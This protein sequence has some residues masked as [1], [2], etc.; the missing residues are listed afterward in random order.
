MRPQRPH[1]SHSII[2]PH[3]DELRFVGGGMHVLPSDVGLWVTNS[4]KLNIQGSSKLS[5]S[6]TTGGVPAGATSITLQHD[7]VGWRVGDEIAITPTLSPS[8]SDHVDSYDL[9]TVIGVDRVTR[10]VTLNSPTTFDHPAVEVEP[11]RV[12]TPE[13]L[14][15]TRNV[16]IE[17]M[18]SRRTHVWIRSKRT[19]RIRN[20]ALRYVGPRREGVHSLASATAVSGR[21][22]LHFH[23]MDDASRGSIVQGVV[24]RDGGSHAF[25]AHQS[26]GVT[27]RD[28]ISHD[29]FGDAYWWDQSSDSTLRSPPTDDVVYERCVAS[30]VRA[31]S[32]AEGLRMG[33]FSLGARNRNAIRNCVAVGVQGGF[34]ASG[35]VWPETSEGEWTFEDCV[36][37]NNQYIGLL[38]WQ[39]NDLPQVIR[40]FIGYHNGKVGIHNGHYING[41][42]YEDSILYANGTASMFSLAASRGSPVQTFSGLRCDQAG[43]SP[44]CVVNPQVAAFPGAAIHFVGCTFRGYGKAALAFTDNGAPFPNSFRIVNCTYEGNEF[45]LGD[46]IHPASR[47][48]IEDPRYGALTLRRADQPGSLR[49]MWNASVT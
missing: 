12:L 40:R 27:F 49:P 6:R 11:G 3:I 22:G 41:F 24:I 1:L 14:N 47:I 15:L 44:Y 18:P 31:E 48:L 7:P 35:F 38:A 23:V 46:K 20:A 25:V 28:C 45:W 42:V 2:F 43:L 4:G 8:H 13:V 16:R 26:H 21:Y 10:R 5:W 32:Q 19:Q 29:T 36:A 37:H 17:G 33:G 34:D 9:V 30:L 39:T